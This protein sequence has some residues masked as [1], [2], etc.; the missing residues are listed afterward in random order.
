MVAD[1]AP[2]SYKSR[3]VV[4]RRIA[5]SDIKVEVEVERDFGRIRGG[6]LGDQMGYGKTACTYRKN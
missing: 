2:P 6:I 5:G 4:S 3:Q 1:A